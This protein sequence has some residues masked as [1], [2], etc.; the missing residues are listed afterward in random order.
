MNKH[1][2]KCKHEETK[3]EYC[4]VCGDF[5]LCI[6]CKS[7]EFRDDLGVWISHKK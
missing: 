6:K 4:G 1:Q 2:N 7:V 3:N 5:K